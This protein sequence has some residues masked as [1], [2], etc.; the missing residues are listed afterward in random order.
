MKKVVG[1][2]PARWQSSRFPGK[3]LVNILGKS[4]IHRS[5]ENATRCST[6]DAVVIA[7][8]DQRIYDHAKEF[9]ADVFMTSPDCPSGTD[10]VWEVIERH[11]NEAQVVVNIQ[12]DEP[13]LDPRVVDSL[14]SLIQENEEVHLTTPVAKIVE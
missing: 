9:G 7:T 2:I 10:R 4:L 11:F 5:F 12:G 14:V 6:L 13:C 3:P 8:D 1:V